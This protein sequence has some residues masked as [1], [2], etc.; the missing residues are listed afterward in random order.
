METFD[1]GNFNQGNLDIAFSA[2]KGYG[3]PATE[4]LTR[5][6][7][8]YPLK[9]LKDFVNTNV[10]PN[11]AESSES[12]EAD[13]SGSS[14]E[15]YNV[16]NPIR[17]MKCGK[18]INVTG[19]VRSKEIIPAS[20]NPIFICKLPDGY[21]PKYAQRALMQSGEGEWWGCLIE[22]S[23]NVNVVRFTKN[24]ANADIPA[25]HWF[26]FSMTYIGG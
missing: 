9:E 6:Q 2:T 4:D 5:K 8:S 26:M 12:D 13:F 21:A 3:N 25:N 15:L 16:E 20:P 7:F 1:Y 23:G 14:F 10:V 19:V 11:L 17:S 18:V 24:N 22:A